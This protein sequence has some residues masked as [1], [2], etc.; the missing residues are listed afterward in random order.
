MIQAPRVI[1]VL[2]KAV[3]VEYAALVGSENLK[4]SLRDGVLHAWE[5]RPALETIRDITIAN[6]TSPMRLF[7]GGGDLDH[8]HIHGGYLNG[9]DPCVPL[10]EVQKDTCQPPACQSIISL[11]RSLPFL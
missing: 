1:T 4:T 10:H 3:F 9:A 11:T 8:R 5:S 2:P 7:T 6:D